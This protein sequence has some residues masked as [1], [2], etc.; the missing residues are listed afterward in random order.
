[1][2]DE[3]DEGTVEALH[4][5]M[6]AYMMKLMEDANL[7]AIHTRRITIQTRDIQL[8]CHIRGEVNWDV[9]NYSL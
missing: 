7:L 5:G 8:A 9:K 4:K 2:P 6:E 1:M 3:V